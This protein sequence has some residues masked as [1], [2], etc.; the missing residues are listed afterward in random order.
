MLI[1]LL[2]T[3]V[4]LLMSGGVFYRNDW[5]GGFIALAAYITSLIIV[6]QR[7]NSQQLGE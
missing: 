7:R 2:L 3:Q 1:Q 5:L 6:L 4:L